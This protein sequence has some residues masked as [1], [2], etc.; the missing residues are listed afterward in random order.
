MYSLNPSDSQI[1][2]FCFDPKVQ[3]LKFKLDIIHLSVY[4]TSLMILLYNNTGKFVKSDMI[5]KTIWYEDD[6]ML[7]ET[8]QTILIAI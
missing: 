1:C 4:E 2:S 8:T 7:K 3:S 5:M 6:Q